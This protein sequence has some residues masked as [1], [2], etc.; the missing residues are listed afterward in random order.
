MGMDKEA[1]AL[2]LLPAR[3]R[4]AANRQIRQAEEIR[5][6]TGGGR[7]SPFPQSV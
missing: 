7:S 2:G 3:W 5:L 6:R 1:L 4:E